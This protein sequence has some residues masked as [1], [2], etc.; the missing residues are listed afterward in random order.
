[1]KYTQ[2]KKLSM[3]LFVLTALFTLSTQG[4]AEVVGLC[5]PDGSGQCAKSVTLT[6][7]T[8]TVILTNTSPVANGGFITADA[9]NLAA[10]TT[11]TNFVTTN[12]N[13]SVIQGSISA[14]PFADRNTLIST[15]GDFEGGGNPRGG[16]AAGSSATFTLTLGGS[17]AAL[18]T[19]LAIFNS[20]AIR[21][22]GFEDGS[23]DKDLVTPTTQ[24][25]APIPEPATMLLL[26][27][28]LAGVAAKIRKRRQAG[29]N[30]QA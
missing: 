8:L 7:N 20:E 21:F 5:D 6:G 29:S 28:G 26:G 1:M 12:T 15:G 22:R 10:N 9:F 3:A 25:P 30:E 14:N 27:T 16:I 24:N 19:E 4:K 18:N 11:I 23:S 17:G 13:F 2:S